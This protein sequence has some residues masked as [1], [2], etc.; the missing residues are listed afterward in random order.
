MKKCEGDCIET[1]GEHSGDVQHVHVVA[2]DGY[3]WGDFWYCRNAIEEDSRRGFV[4]KPDGV[5]E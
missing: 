1:H 5:E 3:D 4:V 2:S